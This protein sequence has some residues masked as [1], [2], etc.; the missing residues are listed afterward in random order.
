MA[1]QKDLFHGD[2]NTTGKLPKQAKGK[3]RAKTDPYTEPGKLL[4]TVKKTKKGWSK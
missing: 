3:N 1:N 2:G 4:P